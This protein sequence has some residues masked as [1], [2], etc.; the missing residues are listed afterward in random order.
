MT[1]GRTSPRGRV[2]PR[3]ET[4]TVSG[5]V[6]LPEPLVHDRACRQTGVTYRCT[7]SHVLRRVSS[8]TEVLDLGLL[9]MPDCPTPTGGS[10]L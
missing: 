5:Q 10:T 1:E 9:L 2:Y 3:S 7:M 4:R 8:G 6:T